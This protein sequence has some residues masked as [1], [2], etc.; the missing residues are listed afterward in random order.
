MLKMVDANKDNISFFPLA[1]IF[2]IFL[3]N[4][5]KRYSLTF[6]LKESV[7]DQSPRK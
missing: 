5:E 6:L 1:R 3:F 4:Y 2:S 7:I